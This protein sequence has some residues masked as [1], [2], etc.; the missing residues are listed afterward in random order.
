V[1]KK[2][3]VALFFILVFSFSITLLGIESAQLYFPGTLDSFWVYEDQDGNELTRH[4]IEGEEIAGETYPA[5]SYDPELEDWV[6]YSPFIHPFLYQIND[7]GIT[8]VVGEEVENTVKARFK[9][10]IETFVEIIKGQAPPGIDTSVFDMGVDVEVEAE[11]NLFLLPDTIAVDEEWDVNEVEVN[12]KLIPLGAGAPEGEEL[13]IDFTI[14]ET[15]IVQGTETVETIAGTFEDCLKVEYRT[16]TTAVMTPNPSPEDIAS[17]G[18]TVTTVWFA[19]NVGI[20]KLH[21]KSGHM[22]LDMIPDDAGF[23][24]ALPPHQERTLELKRFEIKTAESESG[25]SD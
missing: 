16:E 5:F 17:P 13:L 24:G 19:P 1:L 12:A 14:V 21:Q 23:P 3:S 11:E 10:E 4:S 6:N 25:S 18:E 9:N 15:G 2:F 22:F 8:L 20:V 7:V